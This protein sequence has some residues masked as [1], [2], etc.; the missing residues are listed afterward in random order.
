MELMGHFNDCFEWTL[1]EQIWFLSNLDGF[2]LNITILTERTPIKRRDTVI[3]GLNRLVLK[4][5]IKKTPMGQS[6]KHNK[7]SFN[8]ESFIDWAEKVL[9]R[10][11]TGSEPDQRKSGSVPLEVRKR[12][13]SGSE[14]DCT[15]KKENFPENFKDNSPD[16]PAKPVLDM[17][18]A[19]DMFKTIQQ[20]KVDAFKKSDRSIISLGTTYGSNGVEKRSEQNNAR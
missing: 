9:N 17:K 16:N 11:S 19:D 20:N 2:E 12:T 3:K 4:G 6:G 13:I 10:T 8:R 18:W 7:Y 1:L 5:W 15:D 14:P